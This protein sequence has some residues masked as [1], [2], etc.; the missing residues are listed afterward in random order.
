M[1]SR[2]SWKPFMLSSGIV[3]RPSSG[4]CMLPL[5]MA[6]WIES[7]ELLKLVLGGA[8]EGDA[9]MAICISALERSVVKL[10]KVEI[11]EPDSRKQQARESC[12]QIVL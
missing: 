2:L 10:Y 7:A 3:A 8:R 1:Y 12:E 6:L 9:I 4:L 5:K 11:Q